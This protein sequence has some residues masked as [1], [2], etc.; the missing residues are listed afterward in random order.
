VAP[1][2][3]T[4]EFII[5]HF[6]L[7]GSGDADKKSKVDVKAALSQVLQASSSLSL[8]FTLRHVHLDCLGP[9]G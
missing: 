8:F 7:H 6:L 9:A 1:T 4:F 5:D 2:S 3:Q